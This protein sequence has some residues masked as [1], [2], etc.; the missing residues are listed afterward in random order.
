MDN[1]PILPVRKANRT[2]GA[3]YMCNE[4][5]VIWNGKKLKCKHLKNPAECFECGGSQIC[6][7]KRMKNNCKDCGGCGICEH[8]KKRTRCKDCGGGSLCEHNRLNELCRICGGSQICQHN[9]G[10]YECRLCGGTAY[11]NHNKLKRRC[12]HC[13]GASICQH[14]KVKSQ[15][16]ICK[17]EQYLANLIR[18]RV[19]DR[20]KNYSKNNK[21]H[22][23]EYVGCTIDTL[24]EYFGK[25]FKDGMTW[26][27]QGDWHIDHIRPCASF[28]LENENERHMCFHYTN[29]QPLWAFDNMSKNDSY[30]P[31]TFNR[32]WI[33]DHWE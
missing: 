19:S 11:C 10:R 15:C 6:E 33:V 30:D 1:I 29:L 26:E 13:N 25:L 18:S 3:Q 32:N 21:K 31:N 7:H 2:V 23:L 8:G 14:K 27:N 4:K 28:N 16:K 22:T 12:I 9:I 17:P 20:L 24:R 5:L